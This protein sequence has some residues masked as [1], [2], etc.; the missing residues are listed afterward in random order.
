[1]AE[2]QDSFAIGLAY[3]L[4]K[5]LE[6]RLRQCRRDYTQSRI[7]FWKKHLKRV[8]KRID[9]LEAALPRKPKK[10]IHKVQID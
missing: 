6:A 7:E 2:N 4:R 3:L 9:E 8:E 1:M 5:R 10:R